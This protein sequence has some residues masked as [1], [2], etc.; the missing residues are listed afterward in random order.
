[1]HR[2]GI[3]VD[4]LGR[5]QMAYELTR[6]LNRINRLPSYWDIIVFYHTYDK[7]IKKPNF[8]M[9]MEQELW[10]FDAPVL[11]T[12]LATADR[13]IKSPCPTKKFLYVWDLEWT[14]KNYDVDLLASVYMNKNIEL[15]ARSVE[16]AKIITN[17]WRKP[18]EI[19]EGFNYEQL[20]KLLS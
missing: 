7:M 14:L 17:C 18:V 12:D 10:G 13:L 15:V 5:S 19:I 1:M 11:A 4:S 20:A 16:H 8:A 9:M 6:E 3:V 2:A